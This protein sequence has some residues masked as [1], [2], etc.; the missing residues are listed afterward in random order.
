MLEY[1]YKARD[2]AINYILLVNVFALIFN[3][4]RGMQ[5][6]YLLGVVLIIGILEYISYRCFAL[7]ADVFILKVN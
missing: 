4:R 7:I 3:I 5:I 2:K 6:V 1:I